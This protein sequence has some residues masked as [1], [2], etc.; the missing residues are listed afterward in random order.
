MLELGDACSRGVSDA[1]RLGLG[2]A[3]GVQLVGEVL[4]VVADALAK[5]R[6]LGLQLNDGRAGDGGAAGV[7]GLE[8][9]WAAGALG[10]DAVEGEVLV[11]AATHGGLE[12][13]DGVRSS[14][15]PRAWPGAISA[16]SSSRSVWVSRMNSSVGSRARESA[17]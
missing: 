1:L 13:L 5:L 12:A 6:E 15:S 7:R 2:A 14:R 16:R 3:G 4:G 17:V 8:V 10:V 9:G 11:V